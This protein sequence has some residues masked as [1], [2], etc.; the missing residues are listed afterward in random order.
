[1][2]VSKDVLKGSLAPDPSNWKGLGFTN[3]KARFVFAGVLS[4]FVVC[5]GIQ[6]GGA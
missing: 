1:M 4:S 5:V 6:R 2:C 3:Q